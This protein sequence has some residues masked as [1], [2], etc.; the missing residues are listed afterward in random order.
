MISVLVGHFIF[1]LFTALNLPYRIGWFCWLR[2][3]IISHKDWELPNSRIWL[4][5]IDVDRD[6]DGH[7]ERLCVAVKKLQTKMQ[8]HWLFSFNNIYFCKCQKADETKK[9]DGQTL[10]ELNS[11]HLHSQFNQNVS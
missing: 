9:E 7:L 5:E 11:A 1:L 3:F 10:E 2:R 4:A 8:N 6:L